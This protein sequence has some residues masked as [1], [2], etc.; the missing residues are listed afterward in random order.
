MKKVSRIL[1]ANRGEI[2]LRILRACREL[3]IET[4]VVYSEA[5]R[6]AGYLD[7]ADEVVCIGP[8]PSQQSYLD[9]PKIISAAEISAA[10][11]IHP[12]Y[13][14]LAENVHFAEICRSCHIEFIGPPVESIR[15]L[16]DKGA[17]RELAKSVDVPCVPGSEGVLKSE[18]QAVEVAQEIGYP[19][20]V[21]AVAG[22]G[23]RGMRVAH[24]D[25]SLA[26]AFLAARVEA[27]AAFNNPDVYLERYID[28]PRHVEIQILAD[29][30]GNLVHLGER[31]CSLQRRYQ[32]L[33]E[34][35]PSTAVTPDLRERMGDAAKRIVQAAGYANAGTVE[36]LLDAE[37]RFYFIEV[38]TRIQVEHPVSEM[39]CGIDLIKEQ[40]RVASG[41]RLGYSQENIRMTGAAI[42][43]RINA[44]DPA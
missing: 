23:G 16:G 39:V 43:C 41:E 30:H 18:R 10:D 24:N 17:A 31:D 3:D 42:E 38:N 44:E 26:N 25:S 8:G 11:A 28:K 14:F 15:L 36:F 13:G 5:D 33:I 37:G 32:K 2:A 9:I 21:K 34:E 6:G 29:Q 12:G 27:E 7:L 4:V 1:I 35:S 19:V 40:I 20:L 22:G